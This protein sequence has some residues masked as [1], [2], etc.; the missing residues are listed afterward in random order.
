MQC[1]KI[2][3]CHGRKERMSEGSQG[4]GKEENRMAGR[5]RDRSRDFEKTT[6]ILL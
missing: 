3:H 2:K 5:S 6:N 1:A 4:R